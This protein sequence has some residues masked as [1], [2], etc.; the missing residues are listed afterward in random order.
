LCGLRHR[1]GVRGYRSGGGCW[2]RSL[3]DEADQDGQLESEESQDEPCSEPLK[4]RKGDTDDSQQLVSIPAWPV[5]T[6]Y[7]LHTDPATTEPD[8]SLSVTWLWAPYWRK[9]MTSKKA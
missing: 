1:S 8:G 9:P 6:A 2:D 7:A 5:S 4:A 3:G